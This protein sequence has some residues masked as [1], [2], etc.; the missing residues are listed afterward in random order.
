[1]ICLINDF[2]EPEPGEPCKPASAAD[3]QFWKEIFGALLPQ[4]ERPGEQEG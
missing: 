1:M 2:S 4:E 3:I